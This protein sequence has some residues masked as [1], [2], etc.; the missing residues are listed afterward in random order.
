MTATVTVDVAGGP[1]GGA[2]R[3]RAELYR[4]LTRSKRQDVR[5]IGDKR[6]IAPGWLLHREIA[7]PTRGRRVAVNNVS[8][9]APG[10]ERWTLLASPLDFL[11]EDEWSNLHPSLRAGTRRRAPVVHLAAR[12]SDVI[13]APCTAMAER[14]TRVLPSLQDRVVVRLHP[15]AADSISIMPRDPVILC[16]VLFSPYKHMVA[17]ITEW[18]TAINEHIDPSIRLLVTADRSEVPPSVALHSRVELV[19]RLPLSDLRELWA[20]SRA[21]YF[22]TAIESFGFP[23]AEA[24]VHGLPVIARDTAQNR[25]IAR[26]ALCGFT[27]GDQDSLRYA[28]ELALTINVAPDPAPFDPDAYFDW[29][30]GP[31]R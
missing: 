20:R 30:L 10:S 7:K 31:P 17:R 19:G 13:V 14:I 5:V 18:V 8:F 24:R 3:Y 28:T 11:T 16:P 26:Q 1:M 23:L 25:E 27:V 22:P 21:I 2:A 15:V 9:V 29:M 4:Y 6:R 12:R